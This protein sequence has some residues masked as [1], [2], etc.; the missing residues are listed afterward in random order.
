[1]T[2]ELP[3]ADPLPSVRRYELLGLLGKGGFGKVFHA[4]MHSAGFSKDVAIKVLDDPEPERAVLNRFRDE[5]RILGMLRDRAVVNIDQPAFLNGRWAVVMEYVEGRSV[6]HM[7]RYG[8]F[9]PKVALQILS[10]V[11][12]SMQRVFHAPGPDGQPL[13][14]VHRDLKPA[15]LQLT[16]LGE[17]KIL[18]FGIAKGSFEERASST[19][20]HISGSPGFIAPERF[21]GIDEQAGDVFSLGVVLK[22]MLTGQKKPPRKPVPPEDL[23]PEDAELW[24]GGV[25]LA[26]HMSKLEPEERPAM[27]DVEA[28]CNALV[29]LQPDGLDLRHWAEANVPSEVP[30]F[31]DPMLGTVLTETLAT[32]RTAITPLAAAL[33]TTLALAGGAAVLAGAIAVGA[34]VWLYRAEAELAEPPEVAT[35]EAVVPSEPAVAAPPL[36]VAPEVMVAPEP[37]VAPEAPPEP[38]PVAAPAPRPAPV[39]APAPRTAPAGT[40]A[41][42][43]APAEEPAPDA[44]TFPIVITSIPPDARVWI[45]GADRG[46]TPLFGLELTAGRHH[47]RLEHGDDAIER[48]ITVGRRL[49]TRYVWK[50]LEG[51]WRSGF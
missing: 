51:A 2:A 15:N 11:S 40:A 41:P 32:T 36:E 24:K 12:R 14:L 13:S 37:E 42:A 48:T 21:S 43:A 18:D 45:D 1:M 19:T 28:R 9:P 16:P 39:R 27:E 49:P 17:V 44:A 6:H 4:K 23:A 25:E 3:L 38:A 33:G 30:N 50:P 47:L 31:D 8:P 7:L 20:N 29:K 5:A 10:E 22:C 46:A 26:L 35:L 34:A